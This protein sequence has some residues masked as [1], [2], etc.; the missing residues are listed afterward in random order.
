MK[1]GGGGTAAAPPLDFLFISPD[2]PDPPSFSTVIVDEGVVGE[3]TEIALMS[4]ML[5]K[6]WFPKVR[7]YEIKEK[8]LCT[9]TSA[10]IITR[11]VRSSTNTYWAN[12]R[13]KN[14]KIFVAASLEK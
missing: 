14:L 10:R 4:S 13:M 7:S 8:I 12:E 11:R 9:N 5:A 1:M 6:V 3:R 2:P